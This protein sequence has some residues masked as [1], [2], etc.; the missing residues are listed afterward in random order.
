[1]QSASHALFTRRVKRMKRQRP[2]R[3]TGHLVGSTAWRGFGR[4]ALLLCLTFSFALQTFQAHAAA[5]AHERR[6]ALVI[7]N[8]HYENLE[9][10]ANPMNDERLISKTLNELGFEVTERR[11]LSF[12]EFADTVK[13]FSNSAQDAQTVLLYF[14]GHGFQFGGRNYLVPVDATLRDRRR[15]EKETLAVDDIISRLQRRNNQTLIFLD[16]CRNNPMP[17]GAKTNAD[18]QGLAQIENGSGLFVAFATQ[19]GN[20]TR[21]GQGKNSPFAE[22][23]ASYMPTPG[24]SISDMMIRVRNTVEEKTFDNQTPWDQSSL[25]NQFYFNPDDEESDLS[26]EDMAALSK[27]PKNLRDSILKHFAGNIAPAEAPATIA[28]TDANLEPSPKPEPKPE[29]KAETKPDTKPDTKTE[30]PALAQAEPPPTATLTITRVSPPPA[31]SLPAPVAQP[32]TS[33]SQDRQDVVVAAREPVAKQGMSDS[34]AEEVRTV[35]AVKGTAETV[36]PVRPVRPLPETPLL[37]IT[38]VETTPPAVAPPAVIKAPAVALAHPQS[39]SLAPATAQLEHADPPAA[40][41]EP[42]K[43]GNVA[44]APAPPA[45]SEVPLS[46][47]PVSEDKPVE[48]AFAM[49]L[50]PPRLPDEQPKPQPPAEADVATPEED[51]KTYAADVQRQLQRLGCYRGA[52]DG[53]WGKKS[54]AALVRYA[55]NSKQEIAS[56]A[57]SVELLA[58]LRTGRDDLC[59]APAVVKPQSAPAPKPK[60]VSLPSPKAS[61]KPTAAAAPKPAKDVSAVKKLRKFGGFSGP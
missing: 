9:Q 15:F 18:R 60:T 43:P 24:I 17:V 40:T 32:A 36:E 8:S 47:V 54:E 28:P 55:I 35:P 58:L 56:T 16:A 42:E 27:L 13:A 1:M 2:M 33:I 44:V 52:V 48:T 14:A 34:K 10:L 31:L 12:E 49:P 29:I 53:Q 5:P 37:T 25:R 4:F 38:P 21:D 11:D 22:A 20:I 19:P 41:A 3:R 23:L 46:K 57:P 51:Q 7:G 45:A 50:A 30:M 6:V 39:P 59:P 61:Q 26:T